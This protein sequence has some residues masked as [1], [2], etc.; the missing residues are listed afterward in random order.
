MNTI[1][2]YRL[3]YGSDFIGES[4][5]SVYDHCEKILCFVG[6][7]AFGGRRVIRYFGHD[8]YLPHDIDGLTEAIGAWKREHDPKNKVA[9]LPNPYATLLKGQVQRMVNDEVMPRYPDCTHILFV[10]AD[11]VW[12]ERSIG[13]LFEMARGDAI[14]DEFMA[15]PHL[16]WRSPRYCSTRTNPY[17]VLRALRGRKQIGLTGHALMSATGKDVTRRSTGL[18]VHNFGFA[19]SARTI[20]WKHLTALSFSR[21]LN[22]DSPPREAWFE[23]TWRPWN[24]HTNRRTDLCPS[25]GYEDAF[26]P[27][28]EYPHGDLPAAMQRR[29]R[30]SP[31]ADWASAECATAPAC[32]E[33][34]A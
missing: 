14:T 27:A 24:W 29:I 8:V 25:I 12:H 20:F 33:V 7:E 6:H 4:L 31:L 21:D 5:S 1:A 28:E 9:V 23:E 16:F 2:I 32:Q 10:E 13:R 3:L 18:R 15:E 19:A 17:C 34:A 30:T 22:L 11:E 26:P